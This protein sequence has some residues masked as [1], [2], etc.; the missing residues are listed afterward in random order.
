MLA[1]I[2]RCLRAL[3]LAG[4][5]TSLAQAAA[6]NGEDSDWLAR[7]WQSVNGLPDNT[8]TGVVQTPDGFLW[9]GTL[10]GLVRFDGVRFDLFLPSLL[11]N[12]PN[13]LVR[14]VCLDRQGRFWLGMD[15][16]SVV[17]VD[18]DGGVRVFTPNEGML[19]GRITALAEDGAGSMWIGYVD[20]G[21]T[22]IQ[23]DRITRFGAPDGLP[24]RGDSWVRSDAQGDLWIA[25]AGRVATFRNGRFQTVLIET[26][27]VARV[28]QARDGG[29]WI[30]AGRRLLKL[31]PQ[32]ALEDRGQLPVEGEVEPHDLIEDR[33][34]AVWIGTA[35]RGLFRYDGSGFMKVDAS[36]REITC[37]MEDREGNLWAGTGGGGLDLLRPRTLEL[38]GEASGLPFES[39]RSVCED[40][41]GGIWAVTQN[42]RVARRTEAS[43][44]TPSDNADWPGGS[45]SCL[46]ADRDGAVWI[47]TGN[48]GLHRFRD[49]RFRTWRRTDG[50]QGNNVR[51]LLVGS[52]GDVW[53]GL[54][55]P[56]G[57]QRL[58]EEGFHTFAWT[59]PAGPIQAMA[60]DTSGNIWIGTAR[61]RLFR[62]EG[63]NLVDVSAVMRGGP[64]PIRCLHATGDG[65][66]WM[67]YAGAGLGR[68]KAGR[69][70][71]MTTAQGLNDDSISQILSDDRGG[72]WFAGNVGLFK[73]RMDGLAGVAEG[74]LERVPT[75][76]HGPGEGLPNL[77]ATFENSSSVLKD[78]SGRLWMSMRAGLLVIQP[79][80]IRDN[81][82]PPPVL[83]ESVSVD[84]RMVALYDGRSP[85]R[86]RTGQEVIDL[87]T[88]RSPLRLHPDH[89]G[90]EFGFTALSFASPRNVR[91]RYRLEGVDRGWVEGGAQRRAAY[92]RL[93]AG[94]YRFL[95]TACNDAGVWNDTPAELGFVVLPFFWQ[96]W[97]FRV[98]AFT[99][100]TVSIVTLARYV[101]FRRL[102]LRMRLLEQQ[103]ALGRERA[104]IAKDI[105]DDLG[106]NLTQIALLGELARQDRATPDK[107]GE[108]VDKISVTARQA[109]RSLDEIVWAVNP[110]N[111][112]LAHLLEY[113]GQFAL[114]YLR[115]AGIRCRLDY[116]DQIPQRLI[117][118]DTRHNLHLVVKEA[119]NNIVKHSGATEV[120]LRVSLVDSNFGIVIEDNGRGIGGRGDEAGA[121]GLKNIRQRVAD[122]GGECSFDSKPGAGTRISVTIHWPLL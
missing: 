3:F 111:D 51:S 77:Q 91:F 45:A 5:I 42:G 105:H 76:V 10:G 11:T 99:A 68:L 17:R 46:A 72:L 79:G 14:A 81:P 104:R 94:R 84:E 39:I 25:M 82:Y 9:A 87:R 71:R 34:G 35:A 54:D 69:F 116:P 41:E 108:R 18:Q 55:S 53:I 27:T 36:H 1:Q 49:G 29:M 85:L 97:W 112:N 28:A 44:L 115:D 78:R 21:P 74:R 30:A 106:A 96:T 83:V 63:D 60:E 50:L 8:V 80:K 7:S 120:W 16:G 98:A 65:T 33:A 58:R 93:S 75:I 15:L 67:G 48:R 95:V 113:T 40:T 89:S 66:L 118:T 110:R 121:D 59:N 109:I 56:P 37:L 122:I 20:G 61:G 107:A 90:L 23:G 64:F 88:R 119:L 102:R 57:L 70:D 4:W 31:D 101:S 100:F 6:P 52:N 13:P 103:A 12:V 73:A 86:R 92:A 2:T 32:G 24:D 62:V 43:W 114:D 47:G 26:N 117:S 38:L 19:E 22:R